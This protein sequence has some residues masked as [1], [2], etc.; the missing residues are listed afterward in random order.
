MTSFT[1]YS[2]SFP[3]IAMRREEGI[4][5]VRF[6]TRGGPMVWT[7]Q[8][9]EQ[10]PVA[11]AAIAEDPANRVMILTGT[12][13][14]FIA[15][16]SNSSSLKRPLGD[17][18]V[19]H[20]WTYHEKIGFEGRRI[21]QTLL[22]IEIPIIGAVNGKAKIHAELLL[23]S[24]IVLAS[25]K[26]MFQDEP[27]FLNGRVPG[28]GVHVIWPMLIGPN[29]ARYFLL[30]G[31]KISVEEAKDLG[32][33]AEILE[34][35]QLLSRAWELARMLNRRDRLTLRYTRHLFTY[36]FKKQLLEELGLGI[37]LTGIAVGS[38]AAERLEEFKD[39]MEEQRDRDRAKGKR[40]RKKKYHEGVGL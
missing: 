33:V 8:V 29:R 21:L 7:P 2:E 20:G 5:E 19:D 34:P 31:Q 36:R 9:H 24:D 32:L 11:L 6:H 35:D 28:D 15:R 17:G 26:A 39:D 30:T 23:L 37:A 27:H 1:D 38:D 25:S 12:G 13:D 10:L 16:T 3:N 22:D 18:V 40:V 4:L 14:S